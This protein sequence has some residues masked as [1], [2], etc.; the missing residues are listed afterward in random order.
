MGRA[1]PGA[2]SPRRGSPPD[3]DR[4]RGPPPRG[5]TEPACRIEPL[6]EPDVVDALRE[7]RLQQPPRRVAF[8]AQ[9]TARRPERVGEVDIGVRPDR[10]G[11]H[12]RV[13]TSAGV[14][15]M[16]PM[17][18]HAGP[19]CSA[20]GGTMDRG[21]LGPSGDVGGG[22]TPRSAHEAA[23]AGRSVATDRSSHLLRRV[24]IAVL[25][26]H[27]DRARPSGAGRAR[28]VDGE[29]VDRGRARR[30]PHRPLQGRRQRH[31]G[32]GAEVHL[33]RREA[34][35]ANATWAKV[36]AAAQGASVFV[37]LGHGNGWPSIYPPFQT[38]TKD[39]LGLDPSGGG[40]GY[41]GHLL[42]RGLYPRQPPLCAERR[43]S[44]CTTSATPRATPSPGSTRARTRTPDS[45]STTTAR[46]HRRRGA[47]RDRR[48]P[49]RP[50]G[51]PRDHAL[52]TTTGRWIRSSARRRRGTAICTAR[53][54]SQRTPGLAYQMDA[55]TWAPAAS[56]ARSSAT[57][58]EGARSRARR[59]RRRGSIPPTSS[60]PARRRS[61]TG[62]RPAV[63]SLRRPATRRR[64]PPTSCS[65]AAR[66]RITR[67]AEPASDGTGCSP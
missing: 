2:G 59:R 66:L 44:C 65:S 3:A 21:G 20:G 63:R 35:H 41:E 58:P 15:V 61:S 1:S 56:T 54:A 53:I 51:D 47:G 31:R 13:A 12:R 30:R 28:R 36:K 29:G 45:A 32:R 57:W 64:R 26:A 43:S 27:R 52:F 4:R 39:G 22:P 25:A 49:P 17:V 6:A 5:A 42:R 11:R 37:Y 62:R 55:D 14:I 50:P 60:S 48:R 67:E 34:G 24:A 10:Q 38:L 23:L 46:V 18:A 7:D 33:Q 9:R 8:P 16:A 19:G 40:D